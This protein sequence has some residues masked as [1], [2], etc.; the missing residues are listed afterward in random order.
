MYSNPYVVD[1]SKKCFAETILIDAHN[2]ISKKKFCSLRISGKFCLG[3][4]IVAF[5]VISLL[6]KVILQH[7][8]HSKLKSKVPVRILVHLKRLGDQ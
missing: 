1:I 5:N 2:I 4:K 7:C 8:M 3:Q 6:R